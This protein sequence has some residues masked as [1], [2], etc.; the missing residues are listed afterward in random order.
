MFAER[1]DA[2][3]ALDLGRMRVFQRNANCRLV[4][5]GL[6]DAQQPDV[7]KGFGFA[8]ASCHSYTVK[9]ARHESVNIPT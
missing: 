8:I 1:L 6:P 2:G 4:N 9:L 3:K 5:A 7:I